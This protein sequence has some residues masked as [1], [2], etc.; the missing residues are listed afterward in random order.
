MKANPR[1][2]SVYYYKKNT[3]NLFLFQF[4]Y[5]LGAKFQRKFCGTSDLDSFP[6]SFSKA[7]ISADP[8]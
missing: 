2:V 5:Y 4:N 7:V 1:E 8:P 6:A 3:K